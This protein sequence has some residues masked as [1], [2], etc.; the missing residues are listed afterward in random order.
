MNTMTKSSKSLAKTVSR[1]LGGVR[2]L[3]KRLSKRGTAVS[4]MDEEVLEFLDGVLQGKEEH[5]EVTLEVLTRPVLSVQG[6]EHAPEKHRL[7][8]FELFV[9]HLHGLRSGVVKKYHALQLWA[10]LN[11]SRLEKVVR[12]FD[13]MNA[14]PRRRLGSDEAEKEKRLLVLDFDK[15]LAVIDV[16]TFNPS[17]NGEH[18]RVFGPTERYE[19]LVGLLE[20]VKKD[21]TTVSTIVSFNTERVIQSVLDNAGLSGYFKHVIGRE[22]FMA[23][24]YP[25]KS[26]KILELM[27]KERVS[28]N[29]HVIFLDDNAKNIHD[30]NSYI[31][32]SNVV[33]VRNATGLTDEH[34]DE[35][36][37]WLADTGKAEQE[38]S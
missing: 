3:S 8:T 11:K 10:V 25:M 31:P 36:R 12:D 4:E 22:A 18:E 17:V 2:R 20:T 13:V 26:R 1:R 34:Q 27:V 33:W 37:K 29:R 19:S 5:L 6:T 21:D 15:T 23:S 28:D 38:T 9:E 14:S 32:G 24:G 35:V 16:A 30:V 7:T